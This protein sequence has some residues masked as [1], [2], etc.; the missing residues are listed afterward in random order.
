MFSSLMFFTILN[1]GTM[2]EGVALRVAAAEKL[3]DADV[4]KRVMRD[5]HVVVNPFVI[6]LGRRAHC[7]V[8]EIWVRSLLYP[9]CF[10][11]PLLH[12]L[13]CLDLCFVPRAG[14]GFVGVDKW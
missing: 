2:N 7:W 14:R 1:L 8:S 5:L 12:F 6:S 10:C 11:N 3:R 4:Q 13:L 9:F